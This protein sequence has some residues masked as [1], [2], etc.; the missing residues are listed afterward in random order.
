MGYFARRQLALA[1][2]GGGTL[3]QSVAFNPLMGALEKERDGPAGT[4]IRRQ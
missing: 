4:G 3:V 2:P 1:P